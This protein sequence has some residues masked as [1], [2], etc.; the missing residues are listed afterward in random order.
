MIQDSNSGKGKRSSLLRIRPDRS[1]GSP[2]LL[3]KAYRGPF[4]GEKLP[5]HDVDH[6]P[7]YTVQVRNGQSNTST[8]LCACK[9]YYGE[10]FT[11][12]LYRLSTPLSWYEF[13]LLKAILLWTVRTWSVVDWHWHFG[14]ICSALLR[15]LYPVQTAAEVVSSKYFLPVYES[16][17]LHNPEDGN[18]SIHPHYNLKFR[19]S[20][21][22]FLWQ[23][24]QLTCNSCTLNKISVVNISHKILSLSLSLSYTHKLLSS[25]SF[26]PQLINLFCA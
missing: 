14:D 1:C 19:I 23:C 15:R 13:I 7:Q 5:G 26:R 12:L 9:A 10:T 16:T 20:C 6:P 22:K 21:L 17:R 2:I 3:Y 24:R 4:L 11:F 8:S 25:A 18:S